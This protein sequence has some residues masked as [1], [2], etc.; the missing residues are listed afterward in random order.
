MYRMR[1]MH[2]N[3]TVFT[4]PW[5]FIH[6]I[7]T[8]LMCVGLCIPYAC[9]R[10]HMSRGVLVSMRV[11][12]SQFIQQLMVLGSEDSLSLEIIHRN[13]I[14]A[15]TVLILKVIQCLKDSCGKKTQK[16]S[17]RSNRRFEVFCCMTTRDVNAMTVCTL[18]LSVS[19]LVT[20]VLCTGRKTRQWCMQ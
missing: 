15:N 10:D 3:C 19:L 9:V 5:V 11:G 16:N 13:A 2:A 1:A 4:A 20:F 8:F 7:S 14:F 18:L 17:V 12:V 6:N